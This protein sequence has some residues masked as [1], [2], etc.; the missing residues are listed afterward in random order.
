M[1]AATAAAGTATR[2]AGIDANVTS[3]KVASST[4][5]TATCA[6]TVIAARSATRDG[7]REGRWARTRGAATSTPAVAVADNTSP[8]EPASRGSTRTSSSTATARLWRASRGTPRTDAAS[9]TSAIVPARCTLGSNR[10]TNAN[11][12]TTSATASHRPLAPTRSSPSTPST[13]PSTIATLLPET[14]VRWVN[15]VACIA[16]WSSAGSSRVSPVTNP[17]SR[18]PAR[19]SRWRVA[20]SRTRARTCSLARASGPGS[21]TASQPA[22]SSRTLTCCRASQVPYPPS[23][24]GRALARVRHRDPSGGGS[25]SRV[26]AAR[27]RVANPATSSTRSTTCHPVAIGRGSCTTVPTT[28]ASPPCPD[29]RGSS[30]RSVDAIR[31]AD[32]TAV[33][34][35]TASTAIRPGHGDRA[36][37]R[38]AARTAPDR[39]LRLAHRPTTVTITVASP[40][41]P[42]NPARPTRAPTAWPNGAPSHSP[43]SPPATAARAHT[44]AGP[45]TAPGGGPR[46]S[47][48]GGSGSGS[49]VGVIPW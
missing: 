17:T 6:P 10:V 46:T 44:G 38:P 15:P 19:S 34:A 14:A 36:G 16:A 24:S 1:A 41:A 49:S 18:P 12:G 35:T 47:P 48:C 32:P 11:H 40:T 25:S 37:R 3:P 8:S 23:G 31:S 13:P 39:T 45:R 29:R 4:G 27:S 28:S 43:S 26:S 42:T 2:F 21:P 9:S 20:A 22:A 7:N 30:P 5:T 33:M